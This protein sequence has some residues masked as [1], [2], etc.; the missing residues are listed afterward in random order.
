MANPQSKVSSLAQEVS[1]IL[2]M[3]NLDARI[4]DWLG[5]VFNDLCQRV[6]NALFYTTSVDTIASGASSATLGEAVGTPVACIAVSVSTSALY[7]P[8][9][10]PPA[11]FDRAVNIGS[12]IASSTQPL[13][14][15][16]VPVGTTY[17]LRISPPASGDMVM[18]LVWSGNYL[19]SA[20]EADDLLSLPYHFEGVLV[21]GAAW[22]AALSAA[23]DRAM[24][25]QAEFEQALGNMQK[26][27]ALYSDSVPQMRQIEGPYAGFQPEL[28]R[29]PET[30]GP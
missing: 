24:I 18:T 16:I 10:R 15:T 19:A 25:C 29:I 28:P 22:Y 4:Y 5:L 7:I 12:S 14:W 11:E 26:I 6:P 20:P 1:D 23:P 17:M 30:L 3:D 2:G 9:Y 27:L 8:I 21:W 13:I